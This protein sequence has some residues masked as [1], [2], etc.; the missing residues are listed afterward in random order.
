M[1]RIIETV[2]LLVLIAVA[3]LRPLVAETY[4][5]AGSA[6]TQ[7]IDALTDPSPLRTLAFD[8]LILAAVSGWLTARAVRAAPRYR[9]TGLEWGAALVTAGA[10]VSCLIAGNKRLAINASVDWLCYP[11]LTIAL[12]QL[13]SRP[14]QRRLL[15]A[16][17]LASACSG[18]VQCFD[19]YVSHADTVAHYEAGKEEFWA[20]QGVDRDSSKVELFEGRM[21]AREAS[22]FLPHSN[23][24]GAYLVLC[25]FATTGLAI[26]RWRASREV[27]GRLLAG[28]CAV[29]AVLMFAA[30]VLTKSQ[31]ALVSGGAGLVLWAVVAA[32]SGW[33]AAHRVKAVLIGWCLAITGLLAV[34][35]YGLYDG[36]QPGQSLN[37]RWEHLQQ[38]LNFRWEY[39]QASAKLIADH[40]LTG[41]GRENFGRNY[42][43]YKYIAS[44]EEVANPHNLF[45]QA[46][47]DWGILGLIGIVVMLVGASWAVSGR[48]PPG[49]PTTLLRNEMDG[50][51]LLL[52]GLVVFVG[53]MCARLPLLGSSDPSFLYLAVVMTGLP[54]LIGFTCFTVGGRT[55]RG[56]SSDDGPIVC[57]A[58]AVGL[59]T[60]VLHEMINFA[61][62]VPGTAVT[63]FA[64]LAYCIA[65]KRAAGLCP[66]GAATV[67]PSRSGS[68]RR[69]RCLPDSQVGRA[70]PD[71]G[72]ECRAE[73]DLA[74]AEFAIRNPQSAI[75]QAAG[76]AAVHR[77]C[78][79]FVGLVVL[80]AAVVLVLLPQYKAAKYLSLARQAMSQWTPAPPSAQPANTLLRRA[81][82]ADPLD[83]TPC[84][85]WADWMLAVSS[86]PFLTD[87]DHRVEALNATVASLDNAVDRDPF[88][89]SHRR[90]LAR[91]Y[92]LKAA[93]IGR[94]DDYDAAVAAARE[95]LHLY[96]LDPPGLVALGD[97]LLEAGEAVQSPDRLHEALDTYEQALQLDEARPWWETIRRFRPQEVA[98]IKAKM[99][100][101]RQA[102]G[103]QRE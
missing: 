92:R 26:A 93:M 69:P 68:A 73:P 6:L 101:A 96:P 20:R 15:L 36:F 53:V 11:L 76:F 12:V 24:A 31:G 46:A 9:W 72:G 32:S 4:D 47:A 67:E 25:G 103:E 75:K 58:V 63:C 23:V 8:L 86:A 35:G 99:A 19:Q 83:P 71:A 7:A 49:T 41:V 16:G 56:E 51:G 84:A 5:P 52:A 82:E 13:M 50:R 22:G 39:W 81:G 66:R 44:S 55:S 65:E 1:Q 42:L 98:D 48:S 91:A 34:V 85:V 100:I 18:A 17:V 89:V 33:I 3:V 29:L 80:I 78:P 59:F 10:L 54:W 87:K 61:S 14:W 57:T 27:Q 74:S 94:V 60:F 62:F 90:R 64:L 95:A 102:V 37:S 43:Q 97:C 79:P 40:P 77:W 88:N 70:L 28:G 2:S 45:V 38:S 30:T 21:R